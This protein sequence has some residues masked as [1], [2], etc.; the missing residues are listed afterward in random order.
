VIA[1]AGGRYTD[2]AG[3]S[4]RTCPP[5]HLF[6]LAEGGFH[7]VLAGA[8]HYDVAGNLRLRQRHGHDWSPCR[9]CRCTGGQHRHAQP[10][11]HRIRHEL[12]AR[13]AFGSLS[14]AIENG[15]LAANPKSSE[16]TALGLV[17]LIEN[18]I[19]PLVR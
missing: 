7:R 14:V 16:T 6:E 9:H 12:A 2:G 3:T 4:A 5:Q 8:Y 18:R 1:L 10:R 19:A 11:P 15:P 13:G 17:R